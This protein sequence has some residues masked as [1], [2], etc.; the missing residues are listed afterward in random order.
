MLFPIVWCAQ[1]AQPDN[2]PAK[3]NRGLLDVPL[4]PHSIRPDYHD[5]SKAFYSA[6]EDWLA[7]EYPGGEQMPTHLVF[8]DVLLPVSQAWS[9]PVYVETENNVFY[10]QL[11]SLFRITTMRWWVDKRSATTT[12]LLC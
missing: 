2:Q 12:I 6:P 8:F 3:H 10:R 11:T 4:F 1:F 9:W 7:S 5:I